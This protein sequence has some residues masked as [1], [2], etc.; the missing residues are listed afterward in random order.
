MLFDPPNPISSDYDDQRNRIQL[1]RLVNYNA[2]YT[3]S[4][5]ALRFRM[6]IALEF[7]LYILIHFLLFPSYH[8]QVNYKI[9]V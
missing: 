5:L 8:H 9:I 7:K 3:L 1:S 2:F 6:K 4:S